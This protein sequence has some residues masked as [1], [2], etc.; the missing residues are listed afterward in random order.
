MA[1]ER[2]LSSTSTLCH[3]VENPGSGSQA[4]CFSTLLMLAK[5]QAV[6]DDLSPNGPVQV[7]MMLNLE[8]LLFA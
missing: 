3:S 7:N 1:L 2:G 5:A 4:L 6:T 8:L